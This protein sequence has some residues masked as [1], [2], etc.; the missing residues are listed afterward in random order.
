VVE[1]YHK[2]YAPSIGR[3]FEMLVFGDGGHPVVLFPTSMGKYYEA[4]DMGLI[5]SV[6]WFID[7]KKVKIYCPDS[8]DLLSWYNKNALPAERAYNHTCYDRL[9]LDEVLGRALHET[10]FPKAIMAG[11]SFGAYHAINFSFRHPYKVSYVFSMS[12]A[13]DIK[14]RMDG[15]YDDNVYFNNPVDY[16]PDAE[17]SNL[18]NL[19]IVLGAGEHDICR[20]ETEHLSYL[21][22]QKKIDNWLDIRPN[23]VH[24]WPLWKEIF[25]HYLSL[26]H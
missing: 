21:L 9:I 2:W 6:S 18:W 4:K 20:R 17:D 22:D 11:C 26:I 23:Y 10:G 8:I 24:D 12:G 19:G 16:I 15:Y 7:N 14:P 5:E 13:F 3:D 1:N 25:P